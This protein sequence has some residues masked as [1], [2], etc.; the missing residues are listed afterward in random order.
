VAIIQKTNVPL[1]VSFHFSFSNYL[2]LLLHQD[3]KMNALDQL[4]EKAINKKVELRK[5]S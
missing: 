4:K 1:D 3:E 5:Q 2:Y